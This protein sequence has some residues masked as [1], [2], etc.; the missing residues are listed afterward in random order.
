MG[1][2][3][4]NGF[5][6]R[7]ESLSQF[8]RRGS[9][10]GG[11]VRVCRQDNELD[12]VFDGQLEHFC[13]SLRKYRSRGAQNVVI[14]PRVSGQFV[15]I[16][17]SIHADDERMTRGSWKPIS[18]RS[19]QSILFPQLLPYLFWRN[20][21]GMLKVIRLKMILHPIAEIDH[22]TTDDELRLPA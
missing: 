21:V 13:F 6:K 11:A 22:R 9:F 12:T 4:I 16:N 19:R 20:V 17:A 10:L 1:F 15:R 5:G 8:G 14:V 2:T 3:L 18:Y 7:W